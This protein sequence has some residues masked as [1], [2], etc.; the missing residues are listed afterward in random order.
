MG[1][2]GRIER[3]EIIGVQREIKSVVEHRGEI[4]LR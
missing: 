4:E 1:Q 3:K 2:K